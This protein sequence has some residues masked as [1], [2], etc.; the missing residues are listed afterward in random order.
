MASG[1]W[2][3]SRALVPSWS[4][5]S[6]AGRGSRAVVV[7]V[8][9]SSSR[10]CCPDPLSTTPYP[11]TAVP[12]SMPS[13]L[14]GELSGL[15]LRQLR[16]VD[17]EVRGDLG[18]VVQLFQHFHELEDT[19]GVRALD[20]HRVLGHHGELG[21][22]DRELP[23]PKRVLHGVEGGGRGGDDVLVALAGEVLGTRL[24]RGLERRVLIVLDGV[25]IDLAL[26]VEHPGDGV[27]GA[28]VA[29]V[30]A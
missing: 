23:G 2:R 7:R 25:Q 27:G 21:R 14:T 3:A 11:R 22:V 29:A 13:T 26:P 9:H 12:G 17:V 4:T 24:E 6:R 8:P 10:G 19:L 5:R 16:G 28:E 30:P 1:A 20:L 18:D 15:G